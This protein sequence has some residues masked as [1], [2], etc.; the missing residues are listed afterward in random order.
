VLPLIH[1]NHL[2]IHWQTMLPANTQPYD[3]SWYRL[4]Q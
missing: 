3:A 1:T 4:Q 2:H